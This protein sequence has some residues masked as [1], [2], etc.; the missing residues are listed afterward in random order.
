[1]NKIIEK[2]FW[3]EDVLPVNL[4]EP[5][6]PQK[7]G[8]AV[9]GGGFAG[10]S[11][12]LEL[13]HSGVEVTLIEKNWPG[14][15]ACSRNVGFVM[16]RVEGTTGDLNELFHGVKKSDLIREGRHAYDYVLELIMQE[17][18][19]CGLRQRGKLV[20]AT[21]KS[22][23][24][25]M[26]DNLRRQEKQFGTAGAYM[27]PKQDLYKE[28]G[29]RAGEIYYGAK[30]EPNHHDLNPGQLAAGMIQR[31]SDSGATICSST[32]A[33]SVQRL[34]N[35]TYAISTN[36]GSITAEHVVLA[37]QGYS[38]EETEF[39][40]KRIFP[41]LSHVVATEPIPKD[42]LAELLPTLRGV[43]D[44]KQMFFCFRPCDNESRLLLASN[45]LRT[46]DN[47]TQSNRILSSYRK[48]F[49]ELENINAEYCWHGNLAL[50]SDHLPHIGTHEGMHFCATGSF[51]MALYLGAKIAKRILDADDSSSLFDNMPIQKFPLYSGNPALLYRGMRMVFGGLDFLNIAAPK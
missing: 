34:P 9:I 28:I 8:V 47:Y 48:L 2:S 36:R 45:Y 35:G 29:G 3:W 11:A 46:D 32:Q 40:Q 31:L 44:T 24:E 20:L 19:S 38:G 14:Y 12:A 42:L 25:T 21:S 51:S 41:F 49:P 30:I 33:E 50:T 39:L 37:T 6:L 27:L 13:R 15:G 26:A 5:A 23:Y 17:N 18:I 7:T 4:P 1:M 43:V 22:A 10:L 16:D